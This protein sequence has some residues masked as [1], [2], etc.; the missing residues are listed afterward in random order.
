MDGWVF[1]DLAPGDLVYRRT[2]SEPVQAEGEVSP[3]DEQAVVRPIVVVVVHVNRRCVV[4]AGIGIDSRHPRTVV[5]IPVTTDRVSA[6]MPVAMVV[7]MTVEVAMM[8]A[9]MMVMAVVVAVMMMP[10]VPVIGVGFFGGPG[11][12]GCQEQAGGKD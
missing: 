9:M 1:G 7:I 8:V 12:Q 5:T 2:A 4:V 3:S 6:R 11:E 10:V